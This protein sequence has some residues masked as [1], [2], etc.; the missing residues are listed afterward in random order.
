MILVED[1]LNRALKQSCDFE[2]KRKTG[3][4]FA[5]FDRIDRLARH[6]QALSKL[7]LA[8][9]ALGAQHLESALQR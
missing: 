2:G 8:P 4:E 1:R 5:G 7:G 3:I 6:P 9:I